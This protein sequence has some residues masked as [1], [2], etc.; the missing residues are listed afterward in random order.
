MGLIDS[1][2]DMIKKR[3]PSARIIRH[4]GELFGHDGVTMQIECY[5]LFKCWELEEEV[6]T[7]ADKIRRK[8]GDHNARVTVL[9]FE[10]PSHKYIVELD[11]TIY[12]R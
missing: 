5:P 11:V 6:K 3:Y 2:E 1:I 7:L 8:L 9:L 4:G 12:K 10:T